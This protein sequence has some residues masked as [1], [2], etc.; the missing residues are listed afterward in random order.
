MA[1]AKVS[2][3]L[4]YSQL[5]GVFEVPKEDRI[6]GTFTDT[7]SP[8]GGVLTKA[9]A[10]WVCRTV[11]WN[12]KPYMAIVEKTAT[13]PSQ[14]LVVYDV[15]Q[16]RSSWVSGIAFFDLDQYYPDDYFFV[17]FA[18][19]DDEKPTVVKRFHLSA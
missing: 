18:H 14:A 17:F 9:R 5:C 16:C 8:S 3:I 11:D 1:K 15:T 7:V 12:A 2:R 6:V 10:E 13:K 4:P 19:G